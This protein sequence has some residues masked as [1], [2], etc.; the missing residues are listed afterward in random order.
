MAER[1]RDRVAIITGG[2]SGMGAATARQYVAGGGQVLISDLN[3]SA[4]QALVAELGSGV[5]AFQHC[6]VSSQADVDAMVAAAEARFGR[7]DFLFNNA[8]IGGMGSTTDTTPDQWEQV[9]RIDLFSVYYASR[10]VIPVM[11]AQGS[12][13]IVNNASISGLFG[14]FGM[15]SYN[16]AKGAIVNYSRN[17]ALDHAADG[18]R[19]NV[20]CPGAIDTPLF[21][22][23]AQIP[24]LLDAFVAAVP[25]N[26]LGQ[27]EEV[28]EV[29][30]FLASDAASYVTGAVIPVD[31]GVTAATGLPNLNKFMEGLK[32]QYG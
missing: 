2:A 12:G 32:S 1:F 23:V 10:A 31:G 13:V 21:S 24:G 30:A 29:V 15:S 14:D 20:I 5:A 7:I 25:M 19:V 28:A 27:A 4:G 9:L 16:A 18:I 26:R 6:D 11:R 22:G 17:M 3:D 8:G